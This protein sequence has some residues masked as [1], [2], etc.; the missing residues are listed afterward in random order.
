MEGER[1]LRSLPCPVHDL[2]TELHT[3]ITARAHRR[4]RYRSGWSRTGAAGGLAGHPRARATC[5]PGP[6]DGC[7]GEQQEFPPL[8]GHVPKTT[9]PRPVPPVS[10]AAELDG[11]LC[12]RSVCAL[13]W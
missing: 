13:G 8:D 11:K 4:R 9:H 3:R 6:A 12:R 10:T 2:R 7:S 1:H 5:Q